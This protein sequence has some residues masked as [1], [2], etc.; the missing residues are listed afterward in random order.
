MIHSNSQME[1]F[2]VLSKQ[3]DDDKITTL[4]NQIQDQEKLI[5]G[6]QVENEK[7]YQ[8]LKLMKL[9]RKTNEER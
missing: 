5:S 9:D 7:L 1:K 3:S 6:Y 4:Q 8:E 2:K